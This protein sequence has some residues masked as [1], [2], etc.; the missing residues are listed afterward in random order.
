MICLFITRRSHCVVSLNKTLIRCLILIQH[1][2]TGTHLDI[3]EKLG[4]RGG[5]EVECLTRD[6]MAVCSSLAGV[7]A[8]CPSA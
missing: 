3:A 4:E 7:T 6:H 2:R 5:S 8:S 1:W